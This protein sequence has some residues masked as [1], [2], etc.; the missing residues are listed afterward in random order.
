M[1]GGGSGAYVTP[2]EAV[3][4]GLH[5]HVCDDSGNACSWADEADDAQDCPSTDLSALAWSVV[6]TLR[7][8]GFL[9][10]AVDDG[11]L[12]HADVPG[13]SPDTCP[14]REAH[15]RPFRYCPVKGCGWHEG[16]EEGQ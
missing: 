14:E 16:M 2:E 13:L 9:A 4:A 3:V 1:S 6:S 15:G 7:D 11:R 8:A 5:D 12:P 10:P